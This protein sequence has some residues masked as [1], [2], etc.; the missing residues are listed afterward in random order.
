M[1]VHSTIITLDGLRDLDAAAREA[2]GAAIAGAHLEAFLRRRPQAFLE[3][4]DPDADLRIRTLSETGP[5][6][7]RSGEGSEADR[8]PS[9]DRTVRVAPDGD[10]R[11]ERTLFLAVRTGGAAS[12][13]PADLAS[14]FLSADAEASVLRCEVEFLSGG[15]RLAYAELL[16]RDGDF[17]WTPRDLSL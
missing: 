8:A 11:R 6:G 9:A 13:R 2:F 12:D 1:T 17:E 7:D 3:G 4:V 10:P 15:V 5:L 14:R 16:E